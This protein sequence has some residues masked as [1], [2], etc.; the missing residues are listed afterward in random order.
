MTLAEKGRHCKS[1]DKV[2]VDF[3]SMTDAQIAEYFTSYT[4]S[5]CGR[6]SITQLNRDIPLSP[7]LPAFKPLKYIAAWLLAIEAFN[8]KASARELTDVVSIQLPTDTIGTHVADSCAIVDDST[9]NCDT[10]ALETL[11][12][13]KPE[14]DTSV[15]VCKVE[16]TEIT[17]LTTIVL[18]GLGVEPI[19]P[20]DETKWYVPSN[21]IFDWGR[22]GLVVCLGLMPRQYIRLSYYNG[23][24]QPEP[25]GTMQYIYK[26]LAV[27]VR[28]LRLV[29]YRF[30]SK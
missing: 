29:A 25:P 4:G 27:R 16:F 9:G 10:Q 24:R 28:R 30:C 1:C 7:V 12:T 11:V 8:Y 21:M 19:P 13:E 5:T 22:K 18:G 17:G 23:L 20:K 14:I 3:S 15:S 6:I 26:W 2:V